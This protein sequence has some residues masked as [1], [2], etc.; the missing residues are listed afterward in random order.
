MTDAATELPEHDAA[1]PVDFDVRRVSEGTLAQLLAHSE[2][3]STRHV[4][5]LRESERRREMKKGPAA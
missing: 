5:L 1:A 2:P 3:G 4:A